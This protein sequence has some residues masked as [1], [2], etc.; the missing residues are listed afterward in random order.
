M[1][2]G[3][4]A[5]DGVE[6]V[7]P[8]GNDGLVGLEWLASGIAGAG[9]A[10]QMNHAVGSHAGDGAGHVDGVGNVTDQRLALLALVG[11]FPCAVTNARDY[12]VAVC[13]HLLEQTA[14]HEAPRTVMNTVRTGCPPSRGKWQ[15]GFVPDQGGRH[16]LRAALRGTIGSPPL[17]VLRGS[18][19]ASIRR[20]ERRLFLRTA[21]A[22]GSRGG[23]LC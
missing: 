13:T 23:G 21:A 9:S 18:R 11:Q 4:G 3:N 8:G 6:D 17:P 1:A 12:L 14:A 2:Q 7:G 10:G 20:T 15:A 5:S 19:D 22:A 16:P